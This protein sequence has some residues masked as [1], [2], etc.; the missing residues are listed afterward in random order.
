VAAAELGSRLRVVVSV[1][2]RT[3]QKA[4]QP[5]HVLVEVLYLFVDS[6]RTDDLSRRGRNL[7]V[8]KVLV[9]QSFQLFAR[10]IPRSTVGVAVDDRDR[11]RCALSQ[12][13]GLLTPEL[14]LNTS[15]I[16]NQ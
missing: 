8:S 11:F 12:G 1:L 5:R 15:G 10:G 14:G 3:A 7:T 6:V 13:V 9:P 2:D 16:L 4:D